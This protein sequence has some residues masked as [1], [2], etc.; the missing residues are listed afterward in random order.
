MK[1]GYLYLVFVSLASFVV[2]GIL[3]AYKLAGTTEKLNIDDITSDK[4]SRPFIDV[5]NYN[6]SWISRLSSK[7]NQKEYLYPIEKLHIEFN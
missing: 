5:D 3:L 1:R 6:E 4:G 7:K 2:L